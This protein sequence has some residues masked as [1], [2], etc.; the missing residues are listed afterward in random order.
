MTPEFS[1]PF[2][3]MRARAISLWCCFL[4]DDGFFGRASETVAPACLAIVRAMLSDPSEYVRYIAGGSVRYV[5]GTEE[6]RE[7][8]E[9]CR[10][11]A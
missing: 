7:L 11:S 2:P 8:A 9:A 3:F 4:E 1:S 6:V 5:L 10:A